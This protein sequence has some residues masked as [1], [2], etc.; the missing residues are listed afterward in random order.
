MRGGRRDSSSAGF[1]RVVCFAGIACAVAYGCGASEGTT[2]SVETAPASRRAAP[3]GAS[4][5]A[6]VP[7]VGS[8]WVAGLG[9]DGDSLVVLGGLRARVGVDDAVFGLQPFATEIA[10]AAETDHGWVF[11]A[12]DGTVARSASFT[13]RLERLGTLEGPVPSVRGVPASRGRLAVVDARGD[14]FS[15]DGRTGPARVEALP[16]PGIVLQAV[17]L[18]RS[19]GAA[20]LEG[21][22]LALTADGGERWRVMRGGPE[23]VMGLGIEGDEILVHRTD[24]SVRAV[25]R[26]GVER[27]RSEPWVPQELGEYPRARWLRRMAL[28]VFP[29]LVET[30]GAATLDGRA[31]AVLDEDAVVSVRPGGGRAL[32]RIALDPET[33]T[34][35]TWGTRVF[36]LCENRVPIVLDASGRFREERTDELADVAELPMGT[37]G[38]VL[39]DD[40]RHAARRSGCADASTDAS[41]CV[42]GGGSRT[43]RAVPLP[44]DVRDA[45]VVAMHG[46]RALLRG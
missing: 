35:S 7:P 16:E 20:L 3:R 45:E 31:A 30:L 33:C 26:D 21:G 38:V 17:F 29:E 6:F 10:V 23:A 28:W 41:V 37:P 32:D 1:A 44:A 22:L 14:L 24:G 15:S 39:S 11:V 46:A 12:E 5:V 2:R 43:W 13:G 19:R 18:D 36:V 27:V 42:M 4:E 25:A 9:V 34:A 8:A 40:G